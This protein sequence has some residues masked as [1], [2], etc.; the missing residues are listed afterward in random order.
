[1]F[2]FTIVDH[3]FQLSVDQNVQSFQD[4]KMQQVQLTIR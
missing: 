1:M 4:T 3:S 2:A